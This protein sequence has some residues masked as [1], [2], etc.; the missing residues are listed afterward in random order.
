MRIVLITSTVTYAPDNYA[1]VVQSVLDTCGDTV[2]GL[3]LVDVGMRKRLFALVKMLI[4]GCFRMAWQFACNHVRMYRNEYQHM[5]TV[6]NIPYIQT[7][8]PNNEEVLVWTNARQPDLIIHMRTRARL[9]DALL[10][11]PT[12]GCINVHHGL[13]PEQRGL[14]CDL[15]ALAEGIPTGFSIHKMTHEIDGGSI[16]LRHEVSGMYSNYLHYLTVVQQEESKALSILLRTLMREG[17]LPDG[18]S[19]TRS[20]ILYTSDP[21]Y[22]EIRSFAKQGMRL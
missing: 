17:A 13:L 16:L 15:R 8:N 7:R 2:V 12:L 22:K 5:F 6:R 9:S 21:S 19:P 3:V 11:L 10:A 18:S 14:F 4:T 1:T 20:T